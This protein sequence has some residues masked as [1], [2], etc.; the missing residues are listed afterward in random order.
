[1][2]FLLLGATGRTGKHVLSEALQRGHAV[3]ALVRNAEKLPASAKLQ[4]FEGTPADP[5]SL[6]KALWGCEAILSTLNISRK[7]DFPWSPLRTPKDFLSSTMKNIISCAEKNNIKRIIV[8][9]AWGVN[10]S[11]KEIPGWF[12]WFIDHSNIKYPYLDHGNLE[13]LLKQSSLCWTIIRPTGLT[14]S[15]KIREVK[16]SFNANPKPGL[17]ISRRNVARFMIDVLEK[18]TYVRELPTI[19]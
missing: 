13:N 11:R 10:E 8:T 7:N 15:K 3:N 1:M 6:K 4:I 14:N 19:S 9:T 17:T 5:V 12:R 16:I 18:E 2:K